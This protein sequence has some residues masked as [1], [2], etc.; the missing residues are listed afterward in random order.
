VLTVRPEKW[1]DATFA[2]HP[3]AAGRMLARAAGVGGAPPEGKPG[4]VKHAVLENAKRWVHDANI[5]PGHCLRLTMG[6]SGEGTGLELHL[7]DAVN[8]DELDRSH[9]QVAASVR[10]CAP[11]GEAKSVRLEARATAGKLDGILG[12]RVVAPNEPNEPSLGR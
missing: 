7:F 3:L 2:A 12:E 9:A 10:A 11:P 6:V 5:A 4:A 8:G 1:R